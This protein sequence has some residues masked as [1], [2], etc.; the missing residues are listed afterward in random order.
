MAVRDKIKDPLGILSN[1]DDNH[2]DPLGILKKKEP[3]GAGSVGGTESTSPSK[4]SYSPLGLVEKGNIDLNSRPIVKNS[5]G[6]ISTV[7]SISI[8][9]DKGE[10]V[11]PTVSDDGRVMS[12][13]E[14]INQYK[15]TGK[16][17]GIFKDIKS[18]NSY[19]EQ[20]HKDQDAQYT[21]RSNEVDYLNSPQANSRKPFSESTANAPSHVAKDVANI[22]AANKVAKV[23]LIDE[24]IKNSP[25]LETA[26]FK[27]NNVKDPNG[28]SGAKAGQIL[29]RTLN[30]PDFQHRI[31]S[32][33]QLAHEATVV[34]NNLAFT[35][36]EYGLKQIEQKIGQHIQDSGK[37]SLF[38]EHPDEASMDASVEDMVANGKMSMQERAL[39]MKNKGLVKDWV[40][41]QSPALIQSL[42]RGA[43]S[44]LTGLESSIRDI[45]NKATAG[46]LESTG[47][48]ETNEARAE[49]QT[50]EQDATPQ[51]E[52]NTAAGKAIKG[53]EEF[54]GFAAPL[55][56]TTML[57][58]GA[59]LTGEAVEVTPMIAQFEGQNA[60][61]S[62]QLFKDDT[63]SQLAYTLLATTIDASLG[64]LLPTGKAADNIRAI[65][66]K[67]VAE[68]A[69]KMTGDIATDEALK[70]G[71]LDRVTSFVGETAKNSAHTANAITGFQILHNGL[72]AAFGKRDFDLEQEGRDAIDTWK[73][74][75]VSGLPLAGVGAADRLMSQKLK[76]KVTV[77][78][79]ENPEKAIQTIEYQAKINP[80]LEAIKD[81]GIRKIQDVSKAWGSIKNLPISDPAK[82][83][84]L[85][86]D[87]EQKDLDKQAREAPVDVIKSELQDKANEA[88]AEKIK[89]YNGIDT[90]PEHETYQPELKTPEQIEPELK[91]Q[92]GEE[93]TKQATKEINDISEYDLWPEGL[94]K[95]EKE[96]AKQFP[97]QFL[98]EVAEQARTKDIAQATEKN[99][100]ETE[101]TAREGAVN[102]Y[103]EDAV[104][105]AEEIFPNN[106]NENDAL[107]QQKSAS[108]FQY[109][110]SGSGTSR[111]IG[112]SLESGKQ[113]KKIT[114][115]LPEEKE[116]GG[117]KVAAGEG[118][119]NNFGISHESLN[120]VAERIGLKKPERGTFLSPEEQIKR[121]RQ[122]LQGGVDPEKVASDF[123]KDGKASADEI[124]VVRAH[125]E[126]LTKEAQSAY[127]KYG[128]NSPEFAKAKNE[129]Q[130]WQDNV[131][132][133]MGTSAGSSFS[134]LQGET[135]LDT[136]S[137]VALRQAFVDKNGKEPSPAQEKV[138]KELSD[139]VKGLS[140][141]VDDLK[142]KLTEALDKEVNPEKSDTIRQK[143][144]KIASSVRSLKA[145]RPD[146]FSAATPASLVWDGAIEVTAKTIEA[147]GDIAQA[148]VDGISHI[149]ES[150]WY[151]GLGEDKKNAAEQSF[152]ESIDGKVE[153]TPEAKAIKKLQ[154]QLDD[155]R[156]GIVK[157]K[158]ISI[159]DTPEMKDLKDQ[160]FEA[161]KDLGLIKP[162]SVPIAKVEITEEQ[163]RINKLEKQLDDLRQGIVK[164]KTEPF[165]DTK[166]IKDLKDKIFDAK[167]E[168]GLI[169]SKNAKSTPHELK[170]TAA[171]KKIES[172][173]KQKE[174]LENG[175]IKQK[176]VSN[177][178]PSPAQKEKIKQLND[179]IHDFKKNLGLLK[180]KEEK[181]KTNEEKVEENRLNAQNLA[182]KFAN[183]TDNKFTPEEAKDIWDYAKNNYLD[184][185]SDFD[186]MISGTAMDLG[187]TPQ[188]IRDAIIT[189]KG[190]K[191][192]S[193]EMYKKQ[194]ERNTAI[195]RAK[196]WA[197]DEKT[198]PLV[199]FLKTVPRFFFAVKTFGHGTVGMVT[200]S[201]INIY[202]PIEW[203]RYWPTFFKQFKFAYGKPGE[204]EKAMSDVKNDPQF[205]FWKRNGLAV[206]PTERYDEYQFVTKIYEK[207]GKVGRWLTAG[208]RGFNA[209][210]VYR[211]ER[212]KALYNNLSNIEKSDPNTAKEIAKLVN[213]STGTVG[214]KVSDVANTAFFAPKLELSRWNKLI[215]DPAKA[216]KTFANWNNASPAEKATAKIVAARAARILSTYLGALAVNQG[217]LSLSGSNQKINFNNPLSSDW[218]KFKAGDRT[219]DLTGGMISL[220]GFL[221]RVGNVAFEPSSELKNKSRKDEIMNQ[222]WNYVGGKLSP[223]A[224][225]AKDVATHHDFAG[226][227]L[228][229]YDDKPTHS[230]NKKLTMKEYIEKQQT[231]I[232][233]AE[234]FTDFDKQMENEGVPKDKRMQIAQ[235][236]LVAGL[237]GGTGAHIG[238]EPIPKQTAITKEEEKDPTFKYFIDK[239]LELPNTML[240][241]EKV[242][243]KASHTEKKISDYSKDIQ[244]KY[245]ETHKKYL[246]ESLAAIIQKGYVY[247]NPYGD[248][249][250]HRNEE[251]K[252]KD[253]KEL[254]K[255]ELTKVLHIAQSEATT[256]AKKKVFNLK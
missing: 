210:K 154:K 111:N 53:I 8:G 122:L 196:D 185:G 26:I 158:G 11:I 41:Y 216:V 118:D 125:Y 204:Y 247:V 14:A 99:T 135:D 235:S 28:L 241:S 10:V 209:L 102:Y 145:S 218:L 93:K 199:K 248:V 222:G 86:K 132:K 146:T 238:E 140:K 250:T 136:G 44:G 62:R 87:Q 110:Q 73:S 175:V 192:I 124:S 89:I 17:L 177:E 30:D 153:D 163:K 120:K 227:T 106:K 95:M 160:I 43:E 251:G 165:E 100:N 38:Y 37:N 2:P 119:E 224:S 83:K 56:L 152:K 105:L 117:E 3:S 205:L 18:A 168:L 215:V 194:G 193:E 133:P 123:E 16:H 189:P 155:I 69:E 34:Q 206:D 162:K 31:N 90:A 190:A 195:Q 79:A 74:A 228:P 35:H 82:E 70:K 181:P 149:K 67:D 42:R 127:D 156:Q 176:N 80:E 226:N 77:D 225:T 211:L 72:D 166:A 219:L 217:L 231:P 148:I 139:K 45:S 198:N 48:I 134:A 164:S 12:N 256:K 7:R 71:L 15:K 84:F 191:A 33:P 254:T 172:L 202:D 236:I 245:S 232:P 91:N 113:G 76:G 108:I 116:T 244:D 68:T 63:K 47:L 50:A 201:G 233:V 29:D 184:E 114:G 138:I 137:F 19:A 39:Y 25:N 64:K 101:H 66:K 54:T 88:Y 230:W 253:V 58:K 252:R 150:A 60:D 174:D 243:D 104:K 141:D 78:V 61:R 169:P 171:E 212:A 92:L 167:K 129:M 98:K 13:D 200:H 213:H 27:I 6:S 32:D 5:D 249:A 173:E 237:V 157:Q 142:A 23:G 59:G 130:K 239:G 188:Q 208:D 220:L 1:S 57:T 103:G 121:G 223:F 128:K 187:L 40:K 115:T 246:K 52:P 147:G 229:F 65:L 255:E 179:D 36:P 161:K 55:V 207:M 203:K 49:R 240:S 94:P 183:K 107:R 180:S 24:S 85:L 234:F 126:N 9:T 21:K 20:L 144:K 214:L 51:I 170:I 186:H 159:E 221:T 81:E 143:A 46:A 109:P 96:M 22:E 131:I 151:Q 112:K 75:F 197:K 178:E 4:S 97:L 182:E 242:K